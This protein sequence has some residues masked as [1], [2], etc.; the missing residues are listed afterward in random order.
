MKLV[1]STYS[2]TWQNKKV[3]NLTKNK[4]IF[5]ENVRFYNNNNNNKNL[6]ERFCFGF[7]ERESEGV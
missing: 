5:L 3:S 2:K 6:R 7:N 4:F 1:S